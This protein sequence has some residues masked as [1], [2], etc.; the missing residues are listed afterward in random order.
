MDKLAEVLGYGGI[1]G[2]VE[3]NW[4]LKFRARLKFG[5]VKPGYQAPNPGTYL[6]RWWGAGARNNL[7]EST[8]LLEDPLSASTFLAVAELRWMSN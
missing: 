6:G 2:P 5:I 7:A 8:P 3:A 4:P 1:G